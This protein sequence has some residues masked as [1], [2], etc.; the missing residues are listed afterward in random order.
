MITLSDYFGIWYNHPDA[1]D[2]IKGNALALLE[3]VNNLLDYA[4]TAGEID[5]FI[6]PNT[7]NFVAGKTYGGFRPQSCPQGAAGSSH[8]QGRGVDIYDPEH[9]GLT[10]WC[11]RNQSVLVK[12]GLWME[13]P[14]ATSGWCHLTD[15]PPASGRIV[16]RP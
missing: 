12:F 13:H 3:K 2:E 16:F 5:L 7:K 8:K 9:C 14:D 4:T 10:Q 15:R 11:F 6:N 1:T